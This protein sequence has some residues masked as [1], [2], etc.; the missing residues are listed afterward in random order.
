MSYR[1]FSPSPFHLVRSVI[2]CRLDVAGVTGIF[3]YRR[4]DTKVFDE[5]Y[6]QTVTAR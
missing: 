3:V 4:A 6:M 2:L 5:L 1:R